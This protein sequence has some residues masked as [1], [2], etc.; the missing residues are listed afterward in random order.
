M[1]QKAKKDRAKSNAATLNTLHLMSLAFNVSFL[2]I[3]LL[4]RRRSSSFLLYTLLSLP[5]LACEFFLER[6]GRPSYIVSPS[7]TA[8]L[9]SAG[10][11]LAAQGLTEY[12]FD[13]VWVTW[14]C[15]VAVLVVGNLGWGLYAVVPVFAAWKGW[16]LIG[17]ARGLM[18]GAQGAGGTSQEQEQAPTGNRRSRR[19]AA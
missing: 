9:K 7:G 16:G 17:A 10:E 15:L 6:S 1:A 12:M 8:S 14:A 2:L 5:A 18:G 4:F 11:D 13:I 19:V 3:T